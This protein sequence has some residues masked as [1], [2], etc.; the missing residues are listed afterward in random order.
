[1]NEEPAV[2]AALA[3]IIAGLLT[4]SGL[5]LGGVDVAAMSTGIATILA[6]AVVALVTRAHVFSRNSA[7]ALA[8]APPTSLRDP[9]T[10]R[11]TKAPQ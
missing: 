2:I 10:G 8:T 11:Y 9:T 5:A 1:V 3:T 4:S 6:S 7:Q